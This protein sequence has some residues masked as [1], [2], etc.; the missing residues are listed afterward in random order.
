MW[1]FFTLIM[2]SSYTA[3]LA[4]FLANEGMEETIKDIKDLPNQNKVKYGCV[5]GGTT[6]KFFQVHYNTF[7]Y[8]IKAFVLTSD[9]KCT[10]LQIMC[11][12]TVMQLTIYHC[13]NFRVMTFADKP[14]V[15]HLKISFF[16]RFTFQKI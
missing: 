6:Q 5:K 7:T 8:H 10:L 9:K 12:I 11:F 4:A 15:I 1:W 2:I 3:N 16:K 14:I 13:N